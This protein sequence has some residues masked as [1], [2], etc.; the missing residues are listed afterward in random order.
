[1]GRETIVQGGNF[2]K[3]P[4][5]NLSLMV[6]SVLFGL[7]IALL[8]WILPVQSAQSAQLFAPDPEII[9]CDVTSFLPQSEYDALG[10]FYNQLGGPNWINRT[11][12]GN[13][14]KPADTWF[15]VTCSNGHITK[16]EI[17]GN[18]L[19]GSLPAALQNLQYLEVLTI[20][21]EHNM[22]GNIPPE[23]GSLSYLREL[24]FG[25]DDLSGPIPDELR[26]LTNLEVLLLGDGGYSGEIPVWIK[27]LSN[28]ESLSFFYNEMSG[29]IPAEVC[30]LSNLKMLRIFGIPGMGGT[31][32]DCLGN[33]HKL[34][35]LDLSWMDLTGPIP[36]IFSGMTD[37]ITLDLE[38][39]YLEGPIPESITQLSH[40]VRFDP[41]MSAI[42]ETNLNYNM[43]TASEA[44]NDFLYGKLRD[45]SDLQIVPPSDIQAVSESPNSIT[46]SWTPI[47]SGQAPGYYQIFYASQPE[48]PW[49]ERGSTVNKTPTSKLI[50][51]LLSGVP[52][53]FKMRSYTP[54]AYP[55]YG[56][57]P[58]LSQF[59]VPVSTTTM[60][61]GTQME[62]GPLDLELKVLHYFDPDG[63]TT[64]ITVPVGTV[65]ETVT[66]GYVPITTYFG[67]NF[68]DQVFNL[69]AFRDN[70]PVSGYR[71]KLPITMQ[72]GY[73]HADLGD[74]PEDQLGIKI[75][76]EVS[77]TWSDAA[78]T[79][80]PISSYIRNP[81]ENWVKVNV[82]HLSLFAL[83]D[84]RP[85]YT[86]YLP[87]IQK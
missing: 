8:A 41:I 37:L 67:F 79:C 11:N 51:N 72:V 82:C 77:H 21:N 64:T 18:N 32:P 73:T 85:Y 40:L 81:D 63:V 13:P 49:F 31:M 59:S 61:E 52:Y 9:L 56:Q 34:Q 27:D 7:L 87:R 75:Y 58:W 33:L 1:M 57:S 24:G 48:G 22:T 76:N 80:D 62:I 19:V 3:Y 84:M 20:F 45:W 23:L 2:M 74:I 71:L 44:V 39:N 28:L 46:L 68:T 55:E 54:A 29:I 15:G 53:Y 36:D 66:L 38:M 70:L 60:L 6:F 16:L 10:T 25:N 78:Q 69:S 47:G 42:C 26:Y 86:L 4:L 30:Q 50:E 65:T 35:Y 12:W 83:S 17:N 43:L 5:K 14:S